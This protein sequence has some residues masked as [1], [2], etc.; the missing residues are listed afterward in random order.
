MSTGARR[1]E[2]GLE[3]TPPAG[4]LPAVL[5]RRAA[6]LD[7]LSRRIHV[8]QRP[9]RWPSLEAAIALRERGYEPVWHLANRGR[10]I[11]AI[12]TE[13]QVAR[14][15]GVERVLCIRGEHEAEDGIDTPKIREVVRL[16]G[17]LHPTAHVAVTLDHHVR[18]R[19]PR[20]RTLA[21]L[22]A[23]LDAGARAVQ[24]QVTF[25]LD[26]LR[27]FAELVWREDPGVALT[28]MLMPVLTAR[29]AVRLSRRL[30]IP[31]PARL[32]ERLEGFGPEAG[33]DHFRDFASAVFGSPLFAG[34][35]VMTPI[36]PDPDWCARLRTV[37]AEALQASARAGAQRADAGGLGRRA[38]AS[39]G[40]ALPA[41]RNS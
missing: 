21:N 6:A 36:D 16:L 31:L 18:G 2:I 23:K 14:E 1:P 27:P 17:R 5:L 28:P 37:L 24:T 40:G 32:V 9:G 38:E 35:A 10:S 15:A 13:I 26:S 25:D 7:G 4:R 11:A 8:I 33:W 12:E 20:E 34:L 22:R 3:I 19:A 41:L 39:C 30:S 29:A